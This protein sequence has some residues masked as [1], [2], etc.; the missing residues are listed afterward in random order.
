[1]LK[2]LKDVLKIASSLAPAAVSA[3]GASTGFNVADFGALTFAIHVG[4]TAVNDFSS[5][6]KLDIVMQ[7]ADV[8][9]DG[10]YADCADADI[11]NAE[12][13]AS[14]IVKSLDAT[15]DASSVHLA[16]YRGNKKFARI[17]LVETGTVSVPIGIIAIGGYGEFN[18][19]L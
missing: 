12:T 6:H 8:D 15:T 17:R 16:H 19:A 9:S 11:Y 14:G 2:M 18:P 4:A 7:H 5:S 10:S 1:M 3:T 13:G